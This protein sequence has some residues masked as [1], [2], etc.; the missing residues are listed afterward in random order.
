M[1]PR[2]RK[3][4]TKR[5][6]SSKKKAPPFPF[7]SGVA[8]VVDEPSEP[9][10]K[11]P[12]D[13][14][15]PPQRFVH[16]NLDPY[17]V[18]ELSK[19]EDFERGKPSP[20]SFA[21]TFLSH[22]LQPPPAPKMPPRRKTISPKVTSTTPTRRLPVRTI[23]TRSAG[24]TERETTTQSATDPPQS[25]R[26]PSYSPS[27]SDKEYTPATP[28]PHHTKPT[29]PLQDFSTSKLLQTNSKLSKKQRQQKREWLSTTKQDQPTDF[30]PGTTLRFVPEKVR[31][32][33]DPTRGWDLKVTTDGPPQPPKYSEP[34]PPEVLVGF[35][36]DNLEPKRRKNKAG[37]ITETY[38]ANEGVYLRP[39]SKFPFFEFHD[40][41]GRHIAEENVRFDLAFKTHAQRVAQAVDIIDK[42]RLQLEDAENQFLQRLRHWRIQRRTVEQRIAE[43][44]WYSGNSIIFHPNTKDKD[45]ADSYQYIQEQNRKDA[46]GQ[47]DPWVT[48][49]QQ[50][51]MIPRD[52]ISKLD[53]RMYLRNEE[54]EDNKIKEQLQQKLLEL[55]QPDTEVT[56][57]GL[58]S[59]RKRKQPVSDT[60]SSS[61]PSSPTPAPRPT[62]STKGT[63]RSIKAK[64]PAKRQKA[65]EVTMEDPRSAAN[66]EGTSRPAKSK[67]PAK[68]RKALTTA[69]EVTTENPQGAEEVGQQQSDTKETTELPR[70][71]ATTEFTPAT[72]HEAMQIVTRK[73]TYPIEPSNKKLRAQYAQRLLEYRRTLWSEFHSTMAMGYLQTQ[74]SHQ[75]AEDRINDED[76]ANFIRKAAE[77]AIPI[78][79]KDTNWLTVLTRLGLSP[80]PMQRPGSSP[81]ETTPEPAPAPKGVKGSITPTRATP[82]SAM[83]GTT[84]AK[85]ARVTFETTEEPLTLAKIWRLVQKGHPEPETPRTATPQAMQR[86]WQQKKHVQWQRFWNFHAALAIK[87][88][89]QH[90]TKAQAKERIQQEDYAQLFRDLCEQ[91]DGQVTF[92]DDDDWT[93]ILSDAGIP[94]PAVIYNPELACRQ[95]AETVLSTA[96]QQRLWRRVERLSESLKSILFS[97]GP[98][99]MLAEF[100][101]LGQMPADPQLPARNHNANP[102][103]IDSEYDDDANYQQ[104]AK[105]SLH[106]Y[107]I[108]MSM[109]HDE[110]K[111]FAQEHGEDP[112][113]WNKAMTMSCQLERKMGRDLFL[114]YNG[115]KSGAWPVVVEL[116]LQDLRTATGLR[117][118]QAETRHL[119][120]L[121]E[122]DYVET[123]GRIFHMTSEEGEV[124]MTDRTLSKL[125]WTEL[126]TILRLEKIDHRLNDFYEEWDLTI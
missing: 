116:A 22:R 56:A 27:D 42:Y 16:S 92:D 32:R 110:Q 99:K 105:N 24:R 114:Y 100:G 119:E 68:R 121:C 17:K 84:P 10:F 8:V 78:T 71:T 65:T 85:N 75:E 90:M 63:P 31:I 13:I 106:K 109:S 7:P 54:M 73:I 74:L 67:T 122:N 96:Q 51:T 60:D 83:K 11:P 50:S 94:K 113:Y 2:P 95:Y 1:A 58:A 80:P 82:R 104:D 20:E 64:T 53:I 66:T 25:P 30:V 87:D 23:Q 59:P 111:A 34:S 107:M 79:E 9:L 21:H 97:K 81:E 125:E 40:S 41:L 115:D 14:E 39:K 26:E 6:T 112:Y 123:F 37:D 35:S 55:K 43:A 69:A 19:Y 48:G 117:G 98:K 44:E 120:R 91:K 47:I 5:R 72:P 61:P 33:I 124:P 103:D 86:V 38:C 62:P 89:K 101:F 57:T 46:E 102:E 93:S 36:T 18:T 88:L 77:Y 126:I 29:T 70:P 76:F 4:A 118:I 49:R 3:R 28:T 108:L 45:L 52:R 15:S 12:N